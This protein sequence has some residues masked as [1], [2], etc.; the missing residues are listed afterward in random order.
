[1]SRWT[2]GMAPGYARWGLGTNTTLDKWDWL[3]EEKQTYTIAI[4]SGPRIQRN[5]GFMID[6][7]LNISKQVGILL[8][9]IWLDLFGFFVLKKFCHR[10]IRLSWEQNHVIFHGDLLSAGLYTL[11]LPLRITDQIFPKVVPI[12]LTGS[13]SHSSHHLASPLIKLFST[14][15]AHNW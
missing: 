1:M 12:S 14:A 11:T 4:S 6:I 10:R 5:S 3:L 9:K 2:L 13:Y 8:T 15:K 7:Y